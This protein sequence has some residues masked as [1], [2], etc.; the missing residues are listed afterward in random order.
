[1]KLIWKF[2]GKAGDKKKPDG[3]WESLNNYVSTPVYVG[4]RV[5]IGMGSDTESPGKPGALWCLDAR[6]KGDVTKDAVLWSLTGDAFGRT[7]SG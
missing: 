5:I 3:E 7:I 1:M 2:N 6:K 4:H